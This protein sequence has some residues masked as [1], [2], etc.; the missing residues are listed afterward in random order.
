MSRAAGART[1]SDA[2]SG[3]PISRHRVP[4]N[5]T[6]AHVDALLVALDALLARDERFALVIE[7]D[8]AV[9]MTA[10]LRRKVAVALD[11][12]SGGLRRRCVGLAF[13][14]RTPTALGAHT[15]IR[16]LTPAACAERVFASVTDADSWTRARFEPEGGA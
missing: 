9:G 13:V 4:A 11:E 3:P 7:L 14:A 2:P 5:V 10:A 16:W 15:A 12:R 1:H 8:D 6:E